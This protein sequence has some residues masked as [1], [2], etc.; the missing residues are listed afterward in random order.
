VEESAVTKISGGELIT[1]QDD[2]QTP[3][4]P[5]EA[6]GLKPAWIANRGDLNLAEE[7]NIARGLVWGTR[8]VRREPV[9][10]QEFLRRLH[11]KMFDGVWQW[12]G[13]YRDTERNI[14]V[15]PHAISSEI[16]KL[17]DDA[18][19]WN[20]YQTYT[21]D[22]RAV[23]LH[24]R[25][26]FIHPFPNGNGRCARIFADLFLLQQATP[27]FSWG[28]SLHRDAQRGAYLDAIRAADEKNY[29]PLLRFVR[30]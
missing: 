15:T 23:R 7:E 27:Q 22:E 28:T 1:P 12:A 16:R 8:A 25:L 20:Q 19:A 11:L 17:M 10:R 2:G 13:L 18:L 24:H 26:T 5:D 9:L 30:N 29:T 21:M 4:D 3:L 14:G 6:K